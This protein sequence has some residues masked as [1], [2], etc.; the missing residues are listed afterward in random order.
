MWITLTPP[1]FISYTYKNESYSYISMARR[2][3]MKKKDKAALIKII[4]GG[5]VLVG[6]YFGYQAMSGGGSPFSMA[7][8][9][10]EKKPV[11]Y[12]D[13]E[14]VR[15][16]QPTPPT[17]R[18][19]YRRSRGARPGARAGVTSLASYREVPDVSGHGL[20]FNG[21]IIEK[22]TMVEPGLT[23]G[24][25][26]G[27]GKAAK[28]DAISGQRVLRTY[29]SPGYRGGY[30]QQN[31][32][33]GSSIIP[34]NQ[35]G[36]KRIFEGGAVT[37]CSRVKLP[38]KAKGKTQ[39]YNELWGSD[40]FSLLH[41]PETKSKVNKGS[42]SWFGNQG[43]WGHQ[44]DKRGRNI[45][46]VMPPTLAKANLSPDE[47]V[48]VEIGPGYWSGR[49]YPPGCNPEYKY[50]RNLEFS[51]DE[52][53]IGSF[54]DDQNNEIGDYVPLVN[55]KEGVKAPKGAT[56][57]YVS[58]LDTAYF[59]NSGNKWP[60]RRTYPRR[61]KTG[62][63]LV[64]MKPEE[65][66]SKDENSTLL[67]FWVKGK[68]RQGYDVS[69]GLV[70]KDENTH[71]CAVYSAH[72]KEQ[73][74]YINGQAQPK[75]KKN[76][77]GLAKSS[78]NFILG[79]DPRPTVK[80]KRAF[81]G[82]QDDFMIFD[83]A[84]SA[85]EVLKLYLGS[86][87]EGEGEFLAS[88]KG[89]ISSMSKII[90]VVENLR[91]KSV[92]N[93]CRNAALITLD[94]VN[95]Y[96]KKYPGAKESCS[97]GYLEFVKKPWY[98]FGGFKSDGY[99]SPIDI[100]VFINIF[101]DP[102]LSLLEKNNK[103]KEI[104]RI[105]KSICKIPVPLKTEISVAKINNYSTRSRLVTPGEQTLGMWVA[106]GAEA[107]YELKVGVTTCNKPNSCDKST[108]ELSQ[109]VRE[110][111]LYI[112]NTL[113][114]KK[115]P[116][117][118]GSEAGTVTFK[119]SE[120][121]FTIPKNGTTTFTV[122]ALLNAPNGQL[123]GPKSENIVAYLASTD[124]SKIAS[125]SQ[126]LSN[127]AYL[128]KSY[129]TVTVS[130]PSSSTLTTGEVEA[131]KVTV[132][133]DSA[134]DITFKKI[135]INAVSL[136]A[137]IDGAAIRM[138]GMD[139]STFTSINGV[140]AS[141]DGA[142]ITIEFS[143]EQR[144]TAGTSKTYS[145]LLNVTAVGSGSDSLVT[146]LKGDVPRAQ[147]TGTY[148][149]IS[150]DNSFVWSDMAGS[151]GYIH[152]EG[153]EGVEGTEDHLNGKWVETLPSGGNGL[154]KLGGG[155]S[156]CTPATAIVTVNSPSSS[157]LTSGENELIKV[158]ILAKNG[159]LD[160]GKIELEIVTIHAS[161]SKDSLR[162]TMEGNDLA[163]RSHSSLSPPQHPA[164]SL[165]STTTNE[166]EAIASFKNPL[167]I[168][169]GKSI[170][171]SFFAEVNAVSSGYDALVTKLKLDEKKLKTSSYRSTIEDLES[172]SFAW[173]S[174]EVWKNGFG[175]KTL[176]SGT[177]GLYKS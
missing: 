176:P 14:S 149:A 22:V 39:T 105:A 152:T 29:R 3:K 103:C 62:C 130:R 126:K 114:A 138:G 54:T 100:L 113:I 49:I 140:A 154:F 1:F 67:Q 125:G 32:P 60:G 76:I 11:L 47:V 151:K 153:A 150:S 25:T 10:R 2:K 175:V 112:G 174:C 171:L 15:T 40:I 75:G 168:A 41:K 89:I 38:E 157:I 50:C 55:F 18:F 109:E 23:P 8:E 144:L 33:P 7:G 142:D 131:I 21:K 118:I 68:G 20:V 155:S 51:C 116:F 137:S 163:L 108:T 30:A 16:V 86:E 147:A 44:K 128:V 5:L 4:I 45:R 135:V 59:D 87:E 56:R 71:I 158:N 169:K 160:I 165:R 164:G 65:E 111:R 12:Y 117:A 58:S 122:K 24:G 88:L 102:K 143:R 104:Q 19:T 37:V 129:P 94:V 99:L 166:Y 173:L 85:N 119:A 134:G 120:G 139:I 27:P 145:V 26:G 46:G 63:S 79:G 123:G 177:K 42:I 73:I 127:E 156:V 70:Q 81:D 115:P 95:R 6:L 72:K 96:M 101:N 34:N 141:K 28:F 61:Y 57:F 107:V 82:W 133:A 136:V 77:T 84:L 17:R 148:A 90:V 91:S 121:L 146:K 78:Y 97:A 106:S 9:E 124:K 80:G 170:T 98:D 66:S 132:A 162:V 110:L 53:T 83:Q 48:T 74:L 52:K 43:P 92:P 31:T 172:N 64:V 35:A 93:S 69:E 36:I 167:K 161:T 13:F 159:D